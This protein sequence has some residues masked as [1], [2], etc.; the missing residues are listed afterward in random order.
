LIDFGFKYEEFEI[1]FI[2]VDKNK[3]L[4]L[5]IH[6]SKFLPLVQLKYDGLVTLNIMEDRKEFKVYSDLW[7]S[8]KFCDTPKPCLKGIFIQ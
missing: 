6:L 1:E 4:N 7:T 5:I 3:T 8:D 2:D